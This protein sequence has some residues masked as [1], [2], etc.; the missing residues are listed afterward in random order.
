MIVGLQEPGQ[1]SRLDDGDGALGDAHS[2]DDDVTPNGTAAAIARS[3]RRRAIGSGTQ[4]A[5][6]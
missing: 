2:C 5:S 1:E 4:S 3:E 6:H